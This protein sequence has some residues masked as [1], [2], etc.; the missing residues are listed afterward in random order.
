MT[1]PCAG[2]ARTLR[3]GVVGCGQVA[4][5]HLRY[6][7]Q[8]PGV[9]LSGLADVDEENVR[10]LGARYG[11]QNLQGSVENLL[12]S[13]PLD[14][15]HITTPP[16]YHYRQAKL[17][18]EKGINVLV[19]KPVTLSFSE[20]RDLYERAAAQGVSICPDFILLFHPRM[21]EALQL[22]KNG[23]GRVVHVESYLC[24]DPHV[25]RLQESDRLHWSCDLPAGL[26][27]DSLS[28]PLYLLLYWTGAIKSIVVNPKVY[29]VLPQRM[30][31]HMDMIVEG[32]QAT[33]H[34]TL[35]FVTNPRCYYLRM[36]CENGT[37]L[38]NFH[39]MTI[40][41]D[42][43]SHLP[44]AVD[45]ALANF[46]H[47]YGLSRST[48][49]TI[50]E[51]LRGKLLPYQGLQFLLPD[52]YQSLREHREPPISRALALAVS[53]A[54]DAVVSQ[55]GK[56]RLDLRSRPS[57]RAENQKKA[58][59]LVTGASGYV[60]AEVVR[61]L[62]ENGYA[63]RALVR[64]L[65]LTAALEEQ[66]VEIIYGDVRKKADLCQVAA[67]VEV[68]VHLA[69]GLRGSRDFIV[70]TSVNGTQNVADVARSHGVKRVI[71]ISSFSVYD[72]Y[73][74]R[75][76]DTITEASPLEGHPEL[77]GPASLGKRCAEDIAL[78]RLADSECPWTILR[79]SLVMGNGRDLVTPLG[80]MVGNTVISL[81]S[82][83]KRLLLIHV[84][85]MASA[86]IKVI[87]K[88]D[89]AGKVFNVSDRDPVTV[90]QYIKACLRKG[91]Y[92]DVRVIC[93][94]YW[95]ACCGVFGLK[96]LRGLTGKGPRLNLRQMASLYRNLRVDTTAIRKETGWEESGRL[97]KEL[98]L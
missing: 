71:Y 80:S 43:R 29:G 5:H 22:I 74:L 66:G 89:T 79:P 75:N 49:R 1:E 36:F 21:L 41:A 88:P 38:V 13:T 57:S 78:A 12:A 20:T 45:R 30:T 81:C 61:Q 37:V 55:G 15:L 59:V 2:G 53:Q 98:T 31:D 26:F 82:P 48:V 91:R 83:R 7:T 50:V 17:A 39:T 58:R 32:E 35:S 93:I 25:S 4:E 28:H 16:A 56:L 95:F 87:L 46:R 40:V 69:A 34:L 54:E 42:T 47:A 52:F 63:V 14:V 85:D 97:Q 33:A 8:T 73:R 60:G 90:R 19:E 65:A 64:P 51:T 70:E 24:L 92:K 62:L 96:I 9:V 27:H 11:V 94:P 23:L 67:N 44:G 68:I 77:R 72:Y 10:R 86:I 6:I 3:V 76:G 18:I 84:K